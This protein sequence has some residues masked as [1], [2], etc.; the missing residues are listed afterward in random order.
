MDS[1]LICCKKDQIAVRV[2]VGSKPAVGRAGASGRK[3]D[4]RLNATIKAGQ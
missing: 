3:L 1:D 4:Y 2:V